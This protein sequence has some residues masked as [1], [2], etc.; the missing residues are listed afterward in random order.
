M[1]VLIDTKLYKELG[2]SDSDLI[3]GASLPMVMA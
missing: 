3:S 2:H 1:R